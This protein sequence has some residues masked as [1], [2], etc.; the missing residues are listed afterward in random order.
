MANTIAANANRPT[1]ASPRRLESDRARFISAS[2]SVPRDMHGLRG[3]T[4][5]GD[6]LSN[7]KSFTFPALRRF[8]PFPPRMRRKN[9]LSQR[10]APWPPVVR[11][12]W[13]RAYPGRRALRCS[14]PFRRSATSHIARLTNKEEWWAPPRVSETR[15]APRVR[16]V[17]T[18]PVTHGFAV[19]P[20][21]FD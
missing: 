1:R 7:R 15:P 21:V 8:P 4:I 9:P 12:L 3:D 14:S 6:I 2:P 19:I 20:T 5:H 11:V 17:V 10:A 13:D 16:H 18:L